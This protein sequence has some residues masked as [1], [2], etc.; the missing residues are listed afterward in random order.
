MDIRQLLIRGATITI[1]PSVSRVSPDEF[2]AKYGSYMDQICLVAKSEAGTTY[3]PSYTAAK[4]PTYGDF[5]SSFAQIAADIGIKVYAMVHSNVDYY[6]SR[7]P[8]FQMYQSGDQPIEG[9]VCPA[10]QNYWFYLAE[11]AAEVAK[12]PI[13]GIVLKDTLYPRANTCFCESCRKEFSDDNLMDRDFSYDQITAHA[14]IMNKWQQ[15]RIA[16]LSNMI[17]SVVSRVHSETKI[18]IISEIMVDQKTNYLDGAKQHFAQDLNVLSHATN[19]LLLH[20]NP[21]S[22]ALPTPDTPEFQEL[23][24][25]LAPVLEKQDTVNT[26][27]FTWGVTDESF[28]SLEQLRGILGSQSMFVMPDL[29]SSIL[30]RRSLHLGIF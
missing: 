11:I 16:A 17:A 18:D 1:D 8:N 19:H 27:L 3:Y 6:L 20:L 28:G 14:D 9:F 23:V 21:W 7:D 10:R 13:E 24:T 5:F 29:P 25:A 30:D 2:L 4:H 12:Y 22:N 26:S 15:K